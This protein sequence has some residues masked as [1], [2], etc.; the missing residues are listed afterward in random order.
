MIVPNIS[1]VLLASMGI[2]SAVNAYSP[3]FAHVRAALERRQVSTQIS[4]YNNDVQVTK[5]K[6]KNNN[7]RQ[8]G[9]GNNGNAGNGGNAALTLLAANVQAASNTNGQAGGAAA[10][11]AASATDPANFINFCS[12]KTLTNGLQVKSGSC[13]G[14]GMAIPFPTNHDVGLV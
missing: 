14:V 5:A 8:G 13:N 1:T 12:K 3:N 4:Q 11:Q 7:N 9:N 2:V 10:G 6:K